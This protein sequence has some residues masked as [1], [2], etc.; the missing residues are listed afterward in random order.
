MEHIIEKVKKCLALSQSS[1]E[2][3]AAVALRQMQALLAKHNLT[4]TD[5]YHSDIVERTIHHSASKI[6]YDTQVLIKVICD[7]FNCAY[8]FEKIKSRKGGITF[9]GDKVSSEIAEYAFTTLL[10]QM[11]K[12]KAAYLKSLKQLHPQLTPYQ[13]TKMGKTY[14]RFWALAVHKKCEN[15]SPDKDKME[16]VESYVQKVHPYLEYKIT[17]G[18]K[19]KNDALSQ[20]AKAHGVNDGS[21]ANLFHGTGYTPNEKKLIS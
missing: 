8:F 17:S 2:N 4:M 6:P 19:T 7:A 21:E 13:R 10:S 5:V 20:H 9:I 3:E 14:S 12:Q 1:N 18:P 16:K 15:I 11:K